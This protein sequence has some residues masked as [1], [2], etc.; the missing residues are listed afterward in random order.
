MSRPNRPPRIPWAVPCCLLLAALL[1][2]SA[3]SAGRRDD[4]LDQAQALVDQGQAGAAL[5]LVQEVL[6]ERAEHP[7]ALLLRSTARFMVGDLEG[8]AADLE[9]ALEKDPKLRQGWLNLAGLRISENRLGDALAALERAREL[10][11]ANPDSDL[12]Q[13]AVLALQGNVE[14]SSRRFR[15]YL[16]KSGDTAEGHYLVATNYAVAGLDDEAVEHLRQA[17]ERDDRMRLEA[18]TDPAFAH[19][20][21]HPGFALLLETDAWT[22]PDGY[23]VAARVFPETAYAGGRG[24]LLNAVL[25][26]LQLARIAFDSRVEVAA[27]WALI[28]GDAR[29]KVHDDPAGRGVVELAAPPERFTPGEWAETTTRLLDSVAGRTGG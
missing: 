26:T 11:P 15:D 24:P 12:N 4:L 1:L 28:R 5:P 6:D 13:G 2:P 20:A 18:R 8:G 23:R 16:G 7:R 22:P 3:A 10:D 14:A 19:L 9:L 27:S 21:S 25:D 17:V 29:I